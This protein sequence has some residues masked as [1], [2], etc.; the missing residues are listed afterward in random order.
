MISLYFNLFM[1]LGAMELRDEPLYHLHILLVQDGPKSEMLKYE[2]NL[3][4]SKRLREIYSHHPNWGEA[5]K[6][7][8]KETGLLLHAKGYGR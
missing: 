2:K 4:E 3:P 8:I 5:R 1:L 6:A 7:L